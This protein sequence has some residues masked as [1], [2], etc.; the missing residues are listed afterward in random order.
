MQ[1]FEGRVAVVTGAASGMGRAMAERFAQE[2]MKVVLADIEA[3]A[4][5][6]AVQELRQ[7]EHDV[8]GVQTDVSRLDAVENLARETIAAYGKVHVLVNNAGVTKHTGEAVW[9]LSD[10][11][12]RWLLGSNLWGVIHALRVFVPIML[13]QDEEGHI[14]NNSSMAGLVAGSGA[15]G[16]AKH[17]VVSLSEALYFDLQRRGAK[18]G[19]SCLCPGLV[20]TNITEAARNRPPEL[21]NEAPLTVEQQAFMDR[22]AALTHNDG[23]P[24]SRVAEIVIEG[25]RAEQFYLRTDGASRFSGGDEGIRSRFENIIARK[26][27]APF[28]PPPPGTR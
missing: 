4:L 18:I 27:P 24:P 8:I 26:N 20:A 14:V 23:M 9:E 25:M 5:D 28:R 12:W 10:K 11:D 3:P 21:Q 22:I 16:A 6:V 7:A 15:Y 1:S 2:G 13:A 17:A 19:V